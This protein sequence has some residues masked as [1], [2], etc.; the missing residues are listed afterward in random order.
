MVSKSGTTTEPSIAFRIFKNLLIKKYG[1]M[2]PISGS[3]LPL[4]RLR[5][6]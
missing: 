6:L 3:T 2:K 5:V 4:I 1:E